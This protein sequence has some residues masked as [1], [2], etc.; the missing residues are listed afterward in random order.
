MSSPLLR[1]V[2]CDGAK[3]LISTARPTQAWLNHY[4]PANNH[5]HWEG[6][7]KN[8]RLPH[9][10]TTL[11]YPTM[12]RVFC[13]RFRRQVLYI[14]FGQFET[15]KEKSSYLLREKPAASEQR[16]LAKKKKKFVRCDE[17]SGET[18]EIISFSSDCMVYTEILSFSSDYGL[19]LHAGCMTGQTVG[20]DW[21]YLALVQM[22]CRGY[23]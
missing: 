8:L 9:S 13:L 14:L 15:L 5:R 16:T 17:C 20:S 6:R 21:I 10:T 23:P 11:I 7:E 18:K 22:Y 2:L 3:R 1:Y 4:N 12:S 19:V